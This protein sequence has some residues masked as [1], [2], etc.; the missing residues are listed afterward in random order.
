MTQCSG[1][2]FHC[3]DE[4]GRET[5]YCST[6]MRWK[7]SYHFCGASFRLHRL[8]A[9]MKVIDPKITTEMKRF[10]NRMPEMERHEQFLFRD[11]KG[12]IVG[13]PRISLIGVTLNDD[14]IHMEV[15]YWD[16]DTICSYIGMQEK[17]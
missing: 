17:D 1:Y 6:C 16:G 7:C 5:N 4:V 9:Q 2:S 3:E 12:K 15:F 14:K 11:E 13:V 8:E 10:L